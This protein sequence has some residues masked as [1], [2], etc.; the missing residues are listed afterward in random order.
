MRVVASIGAAFALLAIQ[1]SFASGAEE[2]TALNTVELCEESQ[3]VV[4]AKVVSKDEFRKGLAFFFQIVTVEV[5]KVYK[6]ETWISWKG[7]G[8]NRVTRVIVPSTLN[9]GY[10]DG[11]RYILFLGQAVLEGVHCRTDVES[12]AREWGEEFS[13][14]V[15][16]SLEY[17]EKVAKGEV[18]A[19]NLGYT[20][21]KEAIKEEKVFS[22][23]SKQVDYKLAGGQV[24]LRYWAANG[25]LIE[26]RPM[27][28]GREHGEAKRW[29]P[30]GTLEWIKQRRYGRGHG[31]QKR[32][33]KDGKVE[34]QFRHRG[35]EVT[36]EEYK[37]L[38]KSD[39]TLP[40]YEE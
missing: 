31:I 37:R 32:F 4:V 6:G 19:N 8:E 35:R 11:K 40:T 17:I 5:E 38:A 20:I 21:P 14:S 29:Y 18:V 33:S 36:K 25:V 13:K 2:S 7:D 39:L 30:N 1:A 15:A 24:G 27:L 26:E 28:N 9:P 23:G 10:E 22:D 34:I 3:T 16:A 12:K